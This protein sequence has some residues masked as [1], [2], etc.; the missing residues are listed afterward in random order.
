MKKDIKISVTKTKSV[1][2]VNY[3][4]LYNSLK[5]IIR[6]IQQLND[7]YENDEDF[8]RNLRKLLN[9]GG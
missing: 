3:E 9:F 1:D 6:L 8:G 4:E 5:D 7:E 2:R